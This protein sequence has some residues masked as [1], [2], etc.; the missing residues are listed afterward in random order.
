M[1]IELIY[2][3]NFLLDYMILYGTKRL[4]KINTTIKRLILASLIGS[5]TTNILFISINSISLFIIKVIVSIIMNLVTFKKEN[6]IKNTLYFY[7]I[8]III[9]GSIYLLDIKTAYLKI[10]ILIVIPPLIIYLYIKE[11][12]NYKLNY[13]DKYI[14]KITVENKVYNLEGFVDTGNHLKD[15]VTKKSVILVNLEL[16]LNKVLYIPYKALNTEGIIPCIKPEKIEID[17]KI[18]TNCL[19]GIAKDKITIPGINCI[20]PNK[21]KEEL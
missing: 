3:L 21:L 2:I 15:P 20:L 13:K 9:G 8:S 6:L 19:I 11:N 1:Y 4:L 18:I 12:T 14:V 16:P 10:I 17:N 7:L 5:L